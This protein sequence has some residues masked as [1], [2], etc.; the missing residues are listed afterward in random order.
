MIFVGGNKCNSYLFPF[1]SALGNKSKPYSGKMGVNRIVDMALS[2]KKGMKEPEIM[3]T[4]AE[5]SFGKR[6]SILFVLA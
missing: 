1:T 2:G 3:L 6:R 5:L 4:A